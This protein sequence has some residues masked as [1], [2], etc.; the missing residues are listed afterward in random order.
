MG[1]LAKRFHKLQE[2]SLFRGDDLEEAVRPQAQRPVVRKADDAVQRAGRALIRLAWQ[3]PHVA[4]DAVEQLKEAPFPYALHE[5]LL[6]YLAQCD[7]EDRTPSDEE[8]FGTIGEEASAELSRALAEE[9]DTQ[10]AESDEYIRA[11]LLAQLKTAYEEH[12]LRADEMERKGNSDFLQELQKSQRI[13]QRI[14][15]L[16]NPGENMGANG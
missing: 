12:R 11:L 14:D 3:T 7:V 10:E 4:A 8:V 6:R 2:L 5:S 15:H 16:N 1:K 13:K 9:A